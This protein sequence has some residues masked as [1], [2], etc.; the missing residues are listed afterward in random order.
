MWNIYSLWQ[1]REHELINM[2]KILDA[3]QTIESG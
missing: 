2:D 1:N 3:L